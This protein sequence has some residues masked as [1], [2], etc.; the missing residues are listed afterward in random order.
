[1]YVTLYSISFRNNPHYNWASITGDMLRAYLSNKFITPRVIA[2]VLS[3]YT[4]MQETIKTRDN[5]S[6]SYVLL[7]NDD[8]DTE[9]RYTRVNGVLYNNGELVSNM[10]RQ[11]LGESLYLLFSACSLD[12]EFI[13]WLILQ[14]IDVTQHVESLVLICLESKAYKSLDVIL[15]R[16]SGLL[17]TLKLDLFSIALACNPEIKAKIAS[18]L[19]TITVTHTSS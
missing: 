8:D 13:V 14:E 2:S 18:K 9:I 1:M 16:Y 4:N 10:I 15:S 11:R 19:H 5:P 12:L 3:D 17:P 6:V 7:S